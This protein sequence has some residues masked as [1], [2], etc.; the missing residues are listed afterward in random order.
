MNVNF[1]TP[2]TLQAAL[3]HV[4]DLAD[5]SPAPPQIGVIFFGGQGVT[6]LGDDQ[7]IPTAAIGTL[8]QELV[9][10]WP[11]NDG[12]TPLDEAFAE[13]MRII[14]N[15]PKETRVTI[16]LM[17]DGVPSSGRLR[18]DDFPE[19]DAAIRE[20]RLE[21][22]QS[23][24]PPAFQQQLQSRLAQELLDPKSETNVKLYTLQLKLEFE[25][26]LNAA[27]RLKERRVRFATVSFGNIPPLQVIHDT[28]GGAPDDLVVTTPDD[29][30]A[31]LHQLNLLRMPR[32]VQLPTQDQASEPNR[33]ERSTT[34]PIE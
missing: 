2:E 3:L 9:R 34:L 32:V 7:G 16:V 10:E 1:S 25:S 13:A 17:A 5:L 8:K 27:T 21:I 11:A 29:V 33:F 15:L 28:A 26:T 19:V 31:K 4:L 12:A 23:N 18:P 22:T 24:Y 30:I 6:V 14:S 20:L